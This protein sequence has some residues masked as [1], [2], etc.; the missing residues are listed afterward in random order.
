[1]EGAGLVLIGSF[2]NYYVTIAAVFIIGMGICFAS[3]GL[4]T[5]YQTIIPK[6][7]MGR[8]MG[9]VTVL[10]T[11]SVP[12]GT[13]F[14]SMIIG[15]IPMFAILLIFGVIVTLSGLSIIIIARRDNTSIGK[16]IVPG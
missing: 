9:L 3:V 7:K 4:T 13:L 10:L 12:L 6:Q 14:G 11:V 15:Y 16:E 5:L 8:V 2:M 1:M